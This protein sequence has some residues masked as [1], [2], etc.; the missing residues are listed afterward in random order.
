VLYEFGI[1]NILFIEFSNNWLNEISGVKFVDI[2][3]FNESS[4][5]YT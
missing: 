2:I 5:E 1:S 4:N 3:I